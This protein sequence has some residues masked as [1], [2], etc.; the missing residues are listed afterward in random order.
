M[1]TEQQNP[2]PN[3]K[4]RITI[5]QGMTE[6]EKATIHIPVRNRDKTTNLTALQT[7][8]IDAA[9][10]STV[11][12]LINDGK[13]TGGLPYTATIDSKNHLTFYRE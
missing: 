3:G 10:N 6:F 11:G 5:S 4:I 13:D 9:L 7:L 1:L 2:S 12:L 8:K